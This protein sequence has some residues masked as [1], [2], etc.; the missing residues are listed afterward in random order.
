M[1]LGPGGGGK[2]SGL[3]TGGCSAVVAPRTGR[4]VGFLAA[5]ERAWPCVLWEVP[6]GIG[7]PEAAL[8]RTCARGQCLPRA[9]RPALRAQDVPAASSGHHFLLACHTSGCPSRLSCDHFL[10]LV[11]KPTAAQALPAC[12]W[13]VPWVLR[14]L[15]PVPRGLVPRGCIL[16]AH[17]P[18]SVPG[19]HCSS[20]YKQRSKSSVAVAVA[21]AQP[22]TAAP[23]SPLAWELPYA[24]GV[25]LKKT[26]NKN[27]IK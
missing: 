11:A 7:T 5:C 15:E 2:G 6:G 14:V 22:V 18:L 19:T 26:K 1:R 23:I 17:A 25:A 10:L 24:A 20:H 16:R 21:V 8:R 3:A 13:L 9:E 12:T 27:K 4:L